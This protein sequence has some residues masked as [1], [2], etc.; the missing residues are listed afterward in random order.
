MNGRTVITNQDITHMTLIKGV[1][2]R[3]SSLN[4][5]PQLFNNRSSVMAFHNQATK[6]VL[7]MAELILN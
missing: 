7:K 2:F 3:K 6:M 4:Y 5:V 1:K